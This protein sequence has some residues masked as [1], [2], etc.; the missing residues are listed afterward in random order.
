MNREAWRTTVC[1]VTKSWTRL[2]WLSMAQLI[3]EQ[4]GDWSNH[5]FSELAAGEEG[6]RKQRG[7]PGFRSLARWLGLLSTEKWAS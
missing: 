2:K 4:E 6:L 7:R 5:S 3:T 1:G